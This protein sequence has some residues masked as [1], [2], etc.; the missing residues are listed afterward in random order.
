[1]KKFYIP[2]LSILILSALACSENSQVDLNTERTEV[3]L[4]LDN[5]NNAHEK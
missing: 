4:A 5:F 2:L 3:M 1:M